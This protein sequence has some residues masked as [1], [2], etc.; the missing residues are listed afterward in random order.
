MKETLPVEEVRKRVAA[1][2]GRIFSCIFIKRNGEERKMLCRTGVKKGVKGIG[3]A[4]DP[5]EKGLISVY[6][7]QKKDYRFVP[8]D[9][10]L[11][12]K[13]KGTEYQVA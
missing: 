3:L 1:L 5:I 12:I 13:L 2:K 10:I 9:R 11:E 6:D 4:F 7:M 8:I